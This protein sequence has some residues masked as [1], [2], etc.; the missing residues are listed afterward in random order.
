MIKVSP[1]TGQKGYPG[2]GWQ[3]TSGYAS[4][5]YFVMFGSWHTGH[6]LAKSRAGGEPIYAVTD[7]VVKFAEFAGNDGFGNVVF[8]RHSDNLFTRYAHL[9]EIHVRRNEEVK[10]AQ[11]IGL[12]GTTGRSTG[13]HLHFDLMTRSNALDWPGIQRERLLREYINP[14]VWFGVPFTVTPLEAGESTR[15]RVIS[16][17]GL[18][19]RSRPSIS[20]ARLYGLTYGSLVDVK[21]IRVH[22]NDLAWREQVAGGWL[23]EKFLEPVDSSGIGKETAGELP[24][25]EVAMNVNEAVNEGDRVQ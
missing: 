22:A 2:L 19:V 9:R 17:D 4:Q 5:R 23:A 7:G 21:P 15:M 12:L 16:A 25:S 11:I 13:N 1:V 14:E 24:L 8:I 20:G 6:D 18:N 3:I 10:A